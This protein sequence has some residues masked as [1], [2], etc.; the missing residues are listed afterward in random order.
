M[1]VP[2]FDTDRFREVLRSLQPLQTDMIGLLLYRGV[3]TTPTGQAWERLLHC[4]LDPHPRP[5]DCLR[6]YADWF[7]SLGVTGQTWRSQMLE[8]IALDRNPWSERAQHT[9]VEQLPEGLREAAARDLRALQRL[10]E[11]DVGAIHSVVEYLVYPLEPLPREP[12]A[13]ETQI[14]LP[15]EEG[16][17]TCFATLRQDA[18]E[19][20][21]AGAVTWSDRLPELVAFY[22]QWGVGPANQFTCFRWQDQ[23]LRGIANPDPV[24]LA[25]L[26][27]YDRPKATLLQN[28]EFL[29]RGLP[30]Q[31]I[32]LY[33][34]RGSGKSSLIKALPHAYGSQGLRLVEVPKGEL[35][36]LPAIVEDVRSSILKFVVFVDDLSFEEDDEMFKALK[37]VL[38]GSITARPQNLVVYATSNRR[39]LVR[40]FQDDRPRPQDAAEIH[41]WDTVQEK[42]SFSDRF[43]LTLT[44]EPADQD[45]YLQIVHH[46]AQQAHLNQAPEILEAQAKQWA[47]RHNGRS[48]RTARQFID[49]CLSLEK[50]PVE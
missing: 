23:Q 18:L 17:D 20:V 14:F 27:G 19:S 48:G 46:L 2:P 21:F 37:V 28:T 44:F 50:N 33:G 35:H 42:L 10:A 24:T 22:Q 49:W 12:F 7:L 3:L 45:T 47:T 8:A 32:L 15:L 34:S 38:E 36:S 11:V 39:H 6:T 26:V 1:T 41:T 30:A 25:Q 29:L 43:G 9:P 13:Q 4:L 40:E 16:E 5:Q 31:N